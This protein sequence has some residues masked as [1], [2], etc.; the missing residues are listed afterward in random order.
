[1]VSMWTHGMWEITADS[2][3]DGGKLCRN[4]IGKGS[5]G[6]NGYGFSATA[7]GSAPRASPMARIYA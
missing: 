6:G 4:R 1:M 7:A 3:D 5:R 2:R